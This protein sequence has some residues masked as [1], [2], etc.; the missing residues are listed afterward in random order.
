MKLGLFLSAQFPPEASAEEG[1][2]AITEQALLAEELGFESVFLGHHYLAR[3]AFLQPLTLAG[4]LARA[5]TRIRIGFGILLAPL[6]NPIALA[7]ELA[8]LDV[9]SG[10]RL[11]VGIGAGY[12]KIEC[13]AFGVE[14][15]DRVRRLR[16]YVPIL[17]SLWNGE[18]VTAQG[19][20]G[21]VEGARL[22]L[23]CVQE[24]G[25]PLWIG[26]FAPAAIKRAAELDTAWLIG[27]E[28]S[29]ADIAERLEIFHGALDER[30]LT[31]DRPHPL[32]REASIA[33]TT[34][35]AVESV[36]PHLAAQYAAYRS[37]ET[38]RDIDIDDFIRSHCIVGDPESIVARL[39]VLE[40]DLGI[41]DV[42]LRLQYMGMPHEQAL[43]G[44]R[45]FGEQVVSQLATVRA[46]IPAET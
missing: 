19:T 33:A 21:S 18:A 5:T 15:N 30:G 32:T 35:V 43:A 10:G 14:W 20:W 46:R 13:E 8:T 36:R 38:A 1:L 9:L 16:E 28:G 4:Y 17:R 23:R 26:A 44:I 45:L 37:W 12:R 7:E 22:P 2:A 6:Y 39:N 27:P 11:T 25:P 40:R 3:S 34:E 24:G 31:R 42:M 41:T 29:N